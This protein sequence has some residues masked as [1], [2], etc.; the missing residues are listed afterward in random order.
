MNRPGAPT[1]RS[2]ASTGE[3]ITITRTVQITN[4]LTALHATVRASHGPNIGDLLEALGMS[5]S[6]LYVDPG[7]VARAH[8]HNDSDIFIIMV[9]GFAATAHGERMD[10]ITVH[11]PGDIARIPAG[12]PHAAVNLDPDRPVIGVEIRACVPF[13]SDLQHRDELQHVMEAWRA[14]VAAGDLAG[15][16]VELRKPWDADGALPAWEHWLDQFITGHGDEAL[17]RALATRPVLARPAA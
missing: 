2:A 15:D 4:I 12:V 6:A 11:R 5:V 3:L 10:E 13:D 7:D 8:T 17:S 16:L 9:S 1:S 14:R